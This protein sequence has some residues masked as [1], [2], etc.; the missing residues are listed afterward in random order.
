MFID[1][2]F[3]LGGYIVVILLSVK[4]KVYVFDRDLDVIEIVNIFL[5]RFEFKG[6]LIFMLGKFSNIFEILKS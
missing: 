3:G 5:E 1:V 2:I 4:C 6:R